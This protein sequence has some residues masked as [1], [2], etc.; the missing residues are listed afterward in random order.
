MLKYYRNAYFVEKLIDC[1]FQVAI[2][3]YILNLIIA[4]N[5]KNDTSNGTKVLNVI[6]AALP[7]FNESEA[8]FRIL[9][10][11][12]TLLS[13]SYST[14]N[15]NQLIDAVRQSETAVSVLRT[16]SETTTQPNSQN[17]LADCSKEIIDLI[18]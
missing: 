9:V 11:L 3:T 13:A 10:G 18:L 6:F 15:R 12:G 5:K 4:L 17:K 8:I 1:I 2:S 14:E 16:L 7:R